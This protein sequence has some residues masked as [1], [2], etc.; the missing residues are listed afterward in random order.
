MNYF[1]TSDNTLSVLLRWKGIIK[2]VT[3]LL[4]KKKNQ[5]AKKN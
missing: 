3:F 1:H 5:T 4:K 2:E